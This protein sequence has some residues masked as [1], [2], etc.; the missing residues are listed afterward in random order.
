MNIHFFASGIQV[1]ETG[2]HNVVRFLVE[3]S[4][5]PKRGPSRATVTSETGFPVG[6]TFKYLEL[7]KYF[8]IISQQLG[9]VTHTCN[10]GLHSRAHA[11]IYV[12]ACMCVQ[13]FIFVIFLTQGAGEM[14]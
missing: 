3:W 2:L 8:K 10:V 13:S 14:T 5:S 1:E 7:L 11:C 4:R 9:I 12:F 6:K